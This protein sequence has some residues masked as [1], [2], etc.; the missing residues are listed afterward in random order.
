MDKL[1]AYYYD[2]PDEI[3]IIETPEETESRSS[4]G[5]HNDGGD[6]C[7]SQHNDP[8]STLNSYPDSLQTATDATDATHYKE[9][10][11]VNEDVPRNQNHNNNKNISIDSVDS[12]K[13]YNILPNQSVLDGEKTASVQPLSSP[14]SVASVAC[15]A[16]TNDITTAEDERATVKLRNKIKEVGLPPIPCIFCSFSDPIEF[17]LVNH[18]LERH[19]PEL[20]KLPIG[21][22]SMEYRA[23]YAVNLAKRK[24]T[25][26]YEEEELGDGED[27]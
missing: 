18:H 23:E 13:Y 14:T 17:D 16:D 4:S 22:G 25:E 2:V 26:A 6:N 3:K 19:K 24:L 7:S 9:G 11:G 20:F 1:G 10:K 27:L 12:S 5:N 15:V 8:K 21:K